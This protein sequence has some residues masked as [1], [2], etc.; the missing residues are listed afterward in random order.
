MGVKS[1]VLSRMS[2]V[3]FFMGSNMSIR[4]RWLKLLRILIRA[5]FIIGGADLIRM[6]LVKLSSGRFTLGTMASSSWTTA[7][8]LSNFMLIMRQRR[9]EQ[10]MT[11]LIDSVHLSDVR[12]LG[13]RCVLRTG[14]VFLFMATVTAMRT[15]SRFVNDEPVL[16][17]ITFPISQLSNSFWIVTTGV[18]YGTV[19]ELLLLF[20]ERKMHMILQHLSR[21][22]CDFVFVYD[23]V[24]AVITSVA[25]FEEL[26]SFLPVI[27][28][29][30]N[31]ISGA[32]ILN[33]SFTDHDG[34]GFV[35]V[36]HDYL[37]PMLAIL[38]AC[39]GM[40]ARASLVDKVVT[41]VAR[42]DMSGETKLLA[43]TELRRLADMQLTGMSFFTLDRTFLL[44]FIGAVL[45][46]AAL[47]YSYY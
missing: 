11:S 28:F 14:G 18:F 46:Y 10:F 1:K 26:M 7:C 30:N 37:P 8:I 31:L 33:M 12:T 40:D 4:S 5:V 36:T 34:N 44:A 32:G 13:R 2:L 21:G 42:K 9:L 3:L 20:H 35:I 17:L 39:R 45:T 38:S 19:I 16:I 15:Y 29:G 27:W 23:T 24:Q 43:M 41:A 6:M 47:F 22:H 25:R